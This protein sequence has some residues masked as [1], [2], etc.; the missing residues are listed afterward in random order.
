[1]AVAV[2]RSQAFALFFAVMTPFLF[3]QL[4]VAF[5]MCFDAM[6][7]QF[8][9]RRHVVYCLVG[10][11]VL[12]GVH[13][14]LLG[15]WTALLMMVLAAVR[16]LVS[17]R[18]PSRRLMWVFVAL[19]LGAVAATWAGPL[20][21]LSGA[22]ALLPNFAM[23]SRSDKRMRVL[24]MGTTLIWIAHNAVIGS[25][26]AVLMEVMFLAGNLIGYYRIYLRGQRPSVS[27]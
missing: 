2:L 25:P 6:T 19:T 12:I 21:L 27:T 16:N 15:H 10:A 18:G 20:S 3:S 23:F 11:N 1:M 24:I 26:L 22:A 5:A 8:R 14:G 17:L 13:F 4:C 7:F 9:Q